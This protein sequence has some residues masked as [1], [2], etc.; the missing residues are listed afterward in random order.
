MVIRKILFLVSIMILS[1]QL[2]AASSQVSIPDASTTSGGIVTLPITIE[3]VVNMAT[4]TVNLSYN[5]GVVIVQSISAVGIG[6]LTANINNATGITTISAFSTT[7]LSGNITLANITLKA[8]GS[9]GS[10]SSL[11]LAVSS[12]KDLSSNNIPY[13]TRNGTFTIIAGVTPLS[14]EAGGPYSGVA[15]TAV[16]FS[17][18]ANAGTPSYTY[19]WNFG[20]GST[21]S[22]QNPSHTYASI[23]SYTAVLTVTDAIGNTAAYPASVNI[24]GTG[25][26]VVSVSSVQAFSSGTAVALINVSN[27]QNLGAV[28]VKLSYDPAVVIVQSVSAGTMGAPTSSINNTTGITT[29]SIL[30]VTG[31]SGDVILARVNLKAMG[32]VNTSSLIGIVV[33]ALRDVNG[34]PIPFTAT[35]ETFTII[36]GAAP[37]TADAGGPYSGAAGSTI[38]FAGSANGGTLPYTSYSWNFGDLGTSNLQNPSH[39]YS[40]G[41]TYNVVLQVQDATGATASA[42]TTATIVGGGTLISVGSANLTVNST[43]NISIKVENV[44]QL[45]AVALTISYNSSVVTIENVGPGF[46]GS[47]ISNINNAAG[48]TSLSVFS[49]TGGSGNLSL[50]NITLKARS[51]GSTPLTL[52]VSSFTD[53]N[54]IP[55]PNSIKSGKV[56]VLP[57]QKGD[58]NGDGTINIIDALFIAQYTV[59]LRTLSAQQLAAADVNGDGIV[60]IIDAL[61][62]AQYTVGLRQL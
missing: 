11:N 12:L 48:T 40:S 15:G 21:S 25:G 14:A 8:A 41:G 3:N 10:T 47:P 24:I 29:I 58:V 17:G 6:G 7:G 59:G 38:S 61:F 51:L 9:A 56:N 43:A 45:A 4:V 27:V 57:V 32:M 49:V 16:Q 60:N 36:P 33:D 34:N 37:L 13:T 44:L 20:D 26:A 55:I 18:S 46:F 62:I 19:S 54:G 30:S 31:V 39:T 35:N 23:G 2:A 28:T 1:V 52:V 22:L 42:S 5:P 53:A 50:A